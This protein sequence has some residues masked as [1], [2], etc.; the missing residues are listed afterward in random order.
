MI[1][2]PE[3]SELSYAAKLPQMPSSFYSVEQTLRNTDA[4][5]RLT[6]FNLN[7]NAFAGRDPAA[8]RAVKE[9]LAWARTERL[10]PASANLY[11]EIVDGFFSAAIERLDDAI[12]RISNRGEL[13]TVRL[14]RPEGFEL[15]LTRSKG[16]LGAKQVNSALYVAL[17]AEVEPAILALRTGSGEGRDPAQPHIALVDSRW[18]ISRLKA[19]TCM[20]SYQASGFG[21]G[22]FVWSGARTGP[23][24]I[25]IRRSGEPR[26]EL[27]AESDAQGRLKFVVPG[28]A[29]RPMK[30]EARCG[31]AQEG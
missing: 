23:W 27:A 5:R 18:R 25:A 9:R 8:L 20:F 10:M 19:E 14:D 3:S 11:A 30:I 12:W 1:V 29:V 21:D 16:V 13:Q 26:T 4:P 7:Y 28:P 15:D 22:E 2:A 24:H 31:G 17:D 6:A